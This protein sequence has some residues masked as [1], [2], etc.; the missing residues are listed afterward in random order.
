MQ[1]T[2]LVSSA[3]EILESAFL[4]LSCSV[5]SYDFDRKLRFKIFNSDKLSIV[6][7]SEVAIDLAINRGRLFWAIDNTR[8]KILNQKIY[9]KPWKF[10]CDE[11]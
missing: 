5:E 1:T 3:V 7:C 6:D 9:L 11:K 2:I 4:P 10:H 8:K